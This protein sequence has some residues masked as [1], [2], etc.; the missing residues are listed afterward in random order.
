MMRAG[1]NGVRGLLHLHGRARR[2]SERTLTRQNVQRT[3]FAPPPAISPAWQQ[4]IVWP[5]SYPKGC[6]SL[7]AFTRAKN[8][9]NKSD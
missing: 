2:E 7:R 6:A 8:V 4:F 5:G 9:S 3:A 1:A